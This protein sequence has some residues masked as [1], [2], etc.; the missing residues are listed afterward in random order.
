[1]ALQLASADHNRQE[2]EQPIHI[3]IGLHTGEAIRDADKFFGKTVIQAFRIAD[4]AA[5]EEIL[6]SSLTSELLRNAGD[7]HFDDG[8]EVALKGL[9]GSH[10]VYSLA[11]RQAT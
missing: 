4:L 7:L 11:W 3:R 1:M 10:R 2:P 6:T 8:R 9:E 5:G